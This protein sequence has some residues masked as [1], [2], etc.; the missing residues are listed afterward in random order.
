MTSLDTS[1]DIDA[2]PERV[3]EVLMDFEAYPG[4]N[5]FI[6]SIE[7]DQRVGGRLKARLSPPG[8]KGM[9]FKP[10]VQ[11]FEEGT[12]LTWL[13]RLVMPGIFDGRHTLRVEPREGG[14]RFI[15]R[16][17]FTGIL[18]GLM[19]RF[20]GEDTEKGFHLMNGALKERAEAG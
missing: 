3:W 6:T 18:A 2:S 5:P 10:T 9:T 4:W 8:G 20:I 11:V 7:G 17:R 13:G 12:E 15:Q 16:E 19:M 14:S 1:I